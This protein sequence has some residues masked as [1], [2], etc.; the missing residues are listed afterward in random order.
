[1]LFH[2]RSDDSYI[3]FTNFSNN[4]SVDRMTEWPKQI[5]WICDTLFGPSLF[6]LIEIKGFDHSLTGTKSTITLCYHEGNPINEILS[7]KR[8]LVINTCQCVT[9]MSIKLLYWYD[10]DWSNAPSRI[11]RRNFLYKIASN[12]SIMNTKAGG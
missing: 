3:E 6:R 5:L 9:L 12:V 4:F 7:K 1:M 2:F 8:K 11:L 10:I